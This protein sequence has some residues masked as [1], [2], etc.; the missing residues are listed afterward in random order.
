MNGILEIDLILNRQKYPKI[1]H[2]LYLIIGIIL[3]FIIIIFLYKY[4]TYYISKG[5]MIN[6]ELQLLVN[7]DDLKYF[8]ANNKLVIDNKYY[9]YKIS[10]ISD[11]IYADELYQNYKYLY[12][13][14]DNI[15]NIDNYVY[16]I[17]IPKEYK[18]LAKYLKDYLKE[19]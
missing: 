16:E 7:I 11:D 8:D 10:K 4:E 1:Y 5:K 3:V 6:N 14:I 2:P 17:K 18:I 9:N 12:L 19:E 13:Q 15:R